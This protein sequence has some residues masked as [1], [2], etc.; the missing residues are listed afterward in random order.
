MEEKS[1]FEQY[2]DIRRK[3]DSLTILKKDMEDELLAEISERLKGSKEKTLKTEFGNFTKKVN[4]SYSFSTNI[5]EL[6]V[7]NEK[8][9][10]EYV[11]PLKK[12]IEVAKQKEIDEKIAQPVISESLAFTYKK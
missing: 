7:E 11:E 6:A 9:I 10:K 4:T 5:A 2:A 8:K 3:I 12:E 1:M